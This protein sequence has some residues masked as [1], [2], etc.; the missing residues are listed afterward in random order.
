[1]AV[2]SVRMY[3]ANVDISEGKRRSLGVDVGLVD[4]GQQVMNIGLGK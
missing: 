3:M 4:D 1:M 2:I